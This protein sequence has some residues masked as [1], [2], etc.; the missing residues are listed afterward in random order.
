MLVSSSPPHTHASG[1][2]DWLA[3][4]GFDPTSPQRDDGGWL[5]R[6]EALLRLGGAV[7]RGVVLPKSPRLKRNVSMW[8]GGGGVG[9]HSR[10]ALAPCSLIL[11]STL[12]MMLSAGSTRF[13]AQLHHLVPLFRPFPQW[14][15]GCFLHFA[16]VSNPTAFLFCMLMQ[17]FSWRILLDCAGTAVRD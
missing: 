1:Q 4:E 15:R 2:T 6:A 7:G 17:L 10:R 14:P 16:G 8:R 9:A 11:L 5:A 3:R 13:I 12:R